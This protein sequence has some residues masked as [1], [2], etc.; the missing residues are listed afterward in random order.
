MPDDP[1]KE[2]QGATEQAKEMEEA[3]KDASKEREENGGYQ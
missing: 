2:D 3:Q 1:K